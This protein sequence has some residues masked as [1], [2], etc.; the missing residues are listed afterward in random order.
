MKIIDE[1]FV[2]NKKRIVANIR[3]TDAKIQ[4]FFAL[5]LSEKY[6]AKGLTIR[7]DKG[8]IDKIIPY[9]SGLKCM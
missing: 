5:T 8:N 2:K 4:I 3:N 6:P 9:S 1:D 7:E